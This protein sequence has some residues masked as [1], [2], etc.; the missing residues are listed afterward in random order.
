M[1]R[2][3]QPVIECLPA[4]GKAGAVGSRSF[5]SNKHP[6]TGTKALN[7]SSH[8]QASTFPSIPK[9]MSYRMMEATL[10]LGVGYLPRSHVFPALLRCTL[11]TNL[12]DGFKVRVVCVTSTLP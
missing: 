5:C 9:V 7:F 8:S 11:P 6:R 2:D 4:T 12:R 1:M 3:A 10:S